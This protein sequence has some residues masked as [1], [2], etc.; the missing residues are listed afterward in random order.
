[1]TETAIIGPEDVKRLIPPLVLQAQNIT[2]QDAET[3]EW[4]CAFLQSIA[5]REKQLDEVFDPTIEAAHKTHKAA[6]AAKKPFLEQLETAKKLIKEKLVAWSVE[7]ERLRR[8]AENLQA[9]ELKRQADERAATEAAQ[10]EAAGQPDLAEIVREHAA[11]ELAPVVVLESQVP[12]VEGITSRETWDFVIED[13]TKLPREY[14]MP[15][16]KSIRSAVE[17]QKKLCRIPGVRAFPKPGI[18]VRSR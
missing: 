12:R 4:A 13:E 8:E 2:I 18:S 5:T 9:A 11:T 15:D 14:L 16:V 1:M 10:L 3:Y 17:H 7:Q 6:I